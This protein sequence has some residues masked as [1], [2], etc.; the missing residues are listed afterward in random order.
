MRNILKL[1]ATLFRCQMC[2]G[3]M[4]L[5]NKFYRQHV[6]QVPYATCSLEN[7]LNAIFSIYKFP[8]SNIIYIQNVYPQHVSH[9]CFATYPVRKK[10]SSVYNMFRIPNVSY[11]TC[12]LDDI[13]YATLSLEKIPGW[14]H[15]IDPNV[16]LQHVS[17]AIHL[18]CNIFS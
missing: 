4:S 8:A 18:M 13:L 3:N 10:D 17:H 7:I 2:I 15:F 6:L 14:Q 12:S 11:A 16:Y 1:L 9:Y 5:R